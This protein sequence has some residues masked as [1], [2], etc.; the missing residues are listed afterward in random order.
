MSALAANNEES[1]DVV[2]LRALAEKLQGEVLDQAGEYYRNKTKSL[3][4]EDADRRL[5]H[6]EKQIEMAV[7]FL[8]GPPN[9][10]VEIGTDEA[11]Q[12]LVSKLYKAG[13]FKDDGPVNP[14]TEHKL[15]HA[16]IDLFRQT[17]MDGRVTATAD[18][19]RG[20]FRFL[21]DQKSWFAACWIFDITI[22]ERLTAA[23]AE[24]K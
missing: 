23:A 13:I 17:S 15:F 22:S 14:E 1:P 24:E 3:T 7:A 6:M 10:T 19:I 5:V 2:A 21:F 12:D 11:K 9:G 8:A 16:M 20:F 18:D 4:A